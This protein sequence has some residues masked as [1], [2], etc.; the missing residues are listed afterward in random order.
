MEGRVR[1]GVRGVRGG[2]G[3]EGGCAPTC[4]SNRRIGGGA[5]YP[6]PIRIN[7]RGGC[8]PCELYACI[9]VGRALLPTTP[10]RWCSPVQPPPRAVCGEAVRTS[11]RWAFQ[12]GR[13]Q[14]AGTPSAPAR[15]GRQVR[16]RRAGGSYPLP[17]PRGGAPGGR[18]WRALPPP[19]GAPANGPGR[20]QRPRRRGDPPPATAESRRP[21]RGAPRRGESTP[22]SRPRP[23]P[24]CGRGSP[25]A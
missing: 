5:T 12:Q 8:V 1:R 3:A 17:W 13:A 25:A 7:C 19:A 10:T 24:R 20:P 14:S 6:L 9:S 22:G 18:L 11:W 16:A 23:P 2:G 15:P 21:P 4:V